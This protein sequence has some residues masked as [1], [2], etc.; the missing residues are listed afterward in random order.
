MSRILRDAFTNCGTSGIV[1]ALRDRGL[2]PDMVREV[3]AA[4]NLPAAI[5]IIASLPFAGEL[6][7]SARLSLQQ[8]EHIVRRS[9]LECIEKIQRFAWGAVKHFLAAMAMRHECRNLKIIRRRIAY[10]RPADAAA[11]LYDHRLSFLRRCDGIPGS[12]EALNRA[13][14]HSPMRNAFN[15]AESRF[16]ASQ[17]I[18]EFDLALDV[19]CPAAFILP[20]SPLT[21]A[22]SPS[23]TSFG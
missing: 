3:I 7:V 16:A 23:L 21:W 19:E 9:L 4:E 20:F 18:F 22:A 13:L 17:D 2:R 11:L 6:D 8:V 5:G 10:G 15:N 12:V 1:G 14:R